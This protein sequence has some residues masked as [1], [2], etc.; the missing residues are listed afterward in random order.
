M[1]MKLGRLFCCEVQ[2]VNEEPVSSP[3]I[4]DSIKISKK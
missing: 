2:I 3:E 4:N 1:K